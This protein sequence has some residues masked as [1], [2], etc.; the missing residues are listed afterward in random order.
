MKTFSEDNS[1]SSQTINEALIVGSQN[2]SYAIIRCFNCITNV[3]CFSDVPKSVCSVPNCDTKTCTANNCQQCHAGYVIN[4]YANPFCP[5]AGTPC[6]LCVDDYYF[7]CPQA[8]VTF[9][10]LKPVTT[11]LDATHRP[12]K[13]V[14]CARIHTI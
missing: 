3:L 14:L 12:K 5:K 4:Q 6:L 10:H 1:Q 2:M 13:N 7:E 8:N 9:A 11:K